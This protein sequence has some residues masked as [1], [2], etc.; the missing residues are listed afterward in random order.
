MN[1]TK[2]LSDFLDLLPAVRHSP[3]G[4]LQASY[5]KEGDAL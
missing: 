3:K 5:D 2:D 4:R 1:P